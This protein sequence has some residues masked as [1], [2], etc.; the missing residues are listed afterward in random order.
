MASSYAD[1][2]GF[3]MLITEVSY[4]LPTGKEIID[5]NFF[6]V[7]DLKVLYTI[8]SSLGATSTC[9]CTWCAVRKENIDQFSMIFFHL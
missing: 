9:L 8:I 4:D 3:M 6:F 2:E 1:A 7:D 5:V